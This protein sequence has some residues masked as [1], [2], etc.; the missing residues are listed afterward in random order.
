[1]RKDLI[2][3]HASKRSANLGPGS[4]FESVGVFFMNITKPKPIPADICNR[5]LEELETRIIQ[6]EVK[7]QN[8]KIKEY[9]P[10]YNY[11]MHKLSMQQLY[12]TECKRLF[13]KGQSK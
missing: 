7:K 9:L 4:T 6:L 10:V 12:Y 3:T 13:E 2:N 11:E 8:C 5:C 1:M